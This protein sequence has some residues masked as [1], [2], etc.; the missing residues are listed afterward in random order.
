MV[1]KN[2]IKINTSTNLE[3]AKY[4]EVSESAINQYNPKKRKLMK[5]GL[6]I[7]KNNNKL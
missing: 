2:K 4:L 3:L 1:K 5:I 6:Y 7:L